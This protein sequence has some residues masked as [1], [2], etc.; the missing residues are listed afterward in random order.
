M[1]GL[2]DIRKVASEWKNKDGKRKAPRNPVETL[3]RELKRCQQILEQFKQKILFFNSEVK[4]FQDKVESLKRQFPADTPKYD[5]SLAK[6]KQLYVLRQQ[7]YKQARASVEKFAAEVEMA[8]HLS[9]A[10][11]SK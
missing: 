6:M 5:E 11:P 1:I 8:R 7:K 3:Q 10:V 9:N 4:A 2:P